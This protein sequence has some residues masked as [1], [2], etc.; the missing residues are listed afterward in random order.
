MISHRNQNWWQ[1]K[2]ENGNDHNAIWF[3]KSLRFVCYEFKSVLFFF[4]WRT[5][6]NNASQIFIGFKLLLSYIF[7]KLFTLIESHKLIERYELN[8]MY[9]YRW[10]SLQFCHDNKANHAHNSKW[11]SHKLIDS[12]ILASSSIPFTWTIFVLFRNNLCLFLSMKLLN[13]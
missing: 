10:N 12:F 3:P 2:L 8:Y 7:I 1:K 5:K 6:W 4:D 13:L 11:H 9:L